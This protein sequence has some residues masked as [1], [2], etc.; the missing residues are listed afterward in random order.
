MDKGLRSLLR[1]TC[2]QRPVRAALHHSVRCVAPRAA[3]IESIVPSTAIAGARPAEQLSLYKR[4]TFAHCLG[5]GMTRNWQN[6]AV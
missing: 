4:Y 6:S 1:T 2:F 5:V 3:A